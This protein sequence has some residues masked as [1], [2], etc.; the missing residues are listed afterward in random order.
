MLT[1]IAA[2]LSV[3]GYILVAKKKISGFYVWILANLLWV[4]HFR[5]SWTGSMFAVSIILTVY[6]IYE[7]RKKDAK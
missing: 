3:V 4:N 5:Y 7:W 2:I 1:A 6:S